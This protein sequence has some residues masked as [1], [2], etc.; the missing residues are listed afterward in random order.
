MTSKFESLSSKTG[1][2]WVITMNDKKYIIFY[3]KKTDDSETDEKFMS[4]SRAFQS[5]FKFPT[6][7]LLVNCIYFFPFLLTLF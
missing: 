6:E 7:E 5:T 4:A 2:I 1:I 3:L